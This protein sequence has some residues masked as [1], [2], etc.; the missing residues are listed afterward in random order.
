MG[1]A[2]FMLAKGTQV[3]FLFW[4]SGKPNPRGRGDA[5]SKPC[6]QGGNPAWEC[7]EARAAPGGK[8]QGVWKRS[9][10]KQLLKRSDV[11]TVNLV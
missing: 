10:V 3:S 8:G 11:I 9:W 6:C 4:Q 2:L 1:D 5:V 7:T